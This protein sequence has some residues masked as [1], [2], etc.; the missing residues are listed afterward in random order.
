MPSVKASIYDGS[1]CVDEGG[2]L[3]LTGITSVQ[4]NGVF[5]A[6]GASITA[7][8]SSGDPTTHLK[9]GDEIFSSSLSSIGII[10]AL[11]TTAIRYESLK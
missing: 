6:G 10:K 9:V 11:S 1:V 8:A 3:D 7:D 5:T 4:A 2:V